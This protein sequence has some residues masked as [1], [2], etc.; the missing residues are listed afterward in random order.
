LIGFFQ[1]VSI[2]AI[3]ASDGRHRVQETRLLDWKDANLEVAVAAGQG[4]R[5]D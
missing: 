5:D 2:L 4:R 1:H 3:R